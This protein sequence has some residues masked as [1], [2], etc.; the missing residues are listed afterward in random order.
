MK[1]LAADVGG[2]FTDL[3]L[4]DGTTGRHYVDKVPSG[5]RGTAEPIGDGIKQI[6]EQ[7]G[8]DA[9]DIDL[10]V[11]GFTVST[12]ALLMGTGAKAALVTTKGFRDVLEVRN[13]LRPKL[14]S[15]TTNRR[16]PVIPRNRV[17]E[18]DERV[19]SFGNVLVPLEEAE[20]DRLVEDLKKAD[21]AA[22]AVCLTFAH[23]NHE[24]EKLVAERLKQ[25]MPN[26]PVYVS[27]VVNPQIE[28]W[29]RA[30]TT[31]IAAYVGPI[32]NGYISQLEETLEKVGLKASLQIMRSDGGVGT[33]HASRDNPAHTLLSGPAGGVVAAAQLIGQLNIKDAITFDMGGTSAD[34]S[35]IVDGEARVIDERSVSGHPLRLPALDVETISAGG[36]SIGWI[37]MGGALRV[38]PDS[39]GSVPGPACYPNGGDE[40]TVTDAAV[41]LGMLDPDT[42]LGGR[43][44]LNMD[45][46][47]KAINDKI[48][49]TMG[50]S[51]EEAA[52]GIVR[53]ATASMA[54]G[55]RALCVERG[56]DPRRFWLIAFGGAGPLFSGFLARDLE[57]Q[58][59]IAPSHPGV[60]AAEGLLMS[61]IRHATQ[62][63]IRMLADGPRGTAP[64]AEE[65][66]KLRETTA[67][68]LEGDGIPKEK[69]KFRFLAGMRYVG[70]FHRL[71]VPLESGWLTDWDAEAVKARFHENHLAIHGHSAPE[72]PVEL[73]SLHV[74]ALGEIDRPSNLATSAANSGGIPVPNGTRQV[75]FDASEGFVTASTYERAKLPIGAKI[76]GPAIINQLDSTIVVAPDELVSVE[77][78]GSLK[79]MQEAAQ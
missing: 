44:K 60:F 72:T 26:I 42:Y 48:A 50:I 49:S 55:I 73:V 15:V 11:H 33:P 4:Y 28:E 45:A 23:L 19:D 76:H 62:T 35:A 78:E 34:F 69:R 64:F 39:A 7:A 79:I 31:S 5:R 2:T 3:V 56:V 36:G 46:A 18:I 43:I 77:S 65:A 41:V 47:R 27:H 38:G 1:Y 21:P 25:E 63:P 24:H 57:M 74:E 66:E 14:Y 37:D 40:P 22:I 17:F 68:L 20:I 6:L 71:S 53:I 32:V 29:P 61:D 16:D 58:G 12:N 52:L 75:M 59:T 10:F 70:Q 54:Q 8:L 67:A 9:G 13:Q 51:V 30:N